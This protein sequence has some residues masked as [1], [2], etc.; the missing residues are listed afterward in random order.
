V[1]HLLPRGVGPHRLQRLGWHPDGL[2]H[3]DLDGLVAAAL[4]HQPAHP[5]GVVGW[6]RRPARADDERWLVQVQGRDPVAEGAG[7]IQRQ[8]AARRPADQRHRP[9]DDAGQRLQVLDL[10][11]RGVGLDVAAVAAATPV[12]VDD[13]K[14]VGQ[15]PAQAVQVVVVAGRGPD[16]QHGWSAA[17]TS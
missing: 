13:A 9:T 11:G 5:L 7:R 2:G 14:T 8:H 4:S 16:Q 15:Q 17:A 3:E 6:H 10:T 1:G 12:V